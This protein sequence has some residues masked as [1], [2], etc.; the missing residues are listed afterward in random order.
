M[1]NDYYYKADKLRLYK[2]ILVY[3]HFFLKCFPYFQNIFW[4]PSKEKTYFGRIFSGI[5]LFFCQN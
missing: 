4:D 3:S 1:Q 2:G 5:N